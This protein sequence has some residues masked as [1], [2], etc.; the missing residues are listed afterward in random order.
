MFWK[1]CPRRGEL[2]RDL[3]GVTERAAVTTGTMEEQRA[4]SSTKDATSQQREKRKGSW[5]GC[6]TAPRR[7]CRNRKKQQLLLAKVDEAKGE[8]RLGGWQAMELVPALALV[9]LA[10]W[11]WQSVAAAHNWESL[12]A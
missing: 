8:T 5:R 11:C 12:R 9:L 3:D 6:V 10:C 7:V 2:R 1:A 4:S